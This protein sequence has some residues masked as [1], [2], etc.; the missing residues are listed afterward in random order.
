MT[1]R[2]MGP[3]DTNFN[4]PG[5]GG[6][7]LTL[8][9]YDGEPR[10]LDV[11]LGKTVGMKR[12][13]AVRQLIERHLDALAKFGPI[14]TRRG[15]YRGHEV[16]EYLLNEEQ[17]VYIVTQSDAPNALETKVMV[18][19]VFV[20]WRH[21][22][23]APHDLDLLRQIDGISRM[24]SH[25]VTGTEKLVKLMGEAMERADQMNEQ[26]FTALENAALRLADA[27]KNLM[28]TADDR[29]RATV[30]YVSV[31]QLLDEAKALTKGRRSLQGRIF[32]DLWVRAVTTKP[33]VE[34]RR[35]PHGSKPWLFPIGFAAAYM[36]ERGNALVA[37]HNDHV[38]GQGL[39]KFPDRRKKPNP[40]DDKRPGA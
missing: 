37:S 34:L 38:R 36:A 30:E 21:G 15:D 35:S 3:E 24:L 12:P 13:R 23:L 20:A 29:S 32:N 28:L 4:A 1:K 16:T 7:G 9:D 25:K 14:A 11:V 39:I 5:E 10:V 6:G 17:A 40:P 31:C 22:R 8:V 19:K 18:V 33:P 2:T 27:V 26:R